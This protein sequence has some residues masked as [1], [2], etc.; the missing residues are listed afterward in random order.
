VN[1]LQNWTGEMK[2]VWLAK[3]SKHSKQQWKLSTVSHSHW[4]PRTSHWWQ[5]I[6]RHL[7][8]FSAWKLK[9]YTVKLNQKFEYI[10]RTENTQSC[11]LFIVW[12]TLTKVK[13]PRTTITESLSIYMQNKLNNN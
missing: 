8:I 12:E 4:L 10:P 3:S 7:S 1:L 6:S 5:T 11:K 13:I 2:Y 9:L